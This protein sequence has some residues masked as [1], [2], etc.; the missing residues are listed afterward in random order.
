MEATQ[1]F[2]KQKQQREEKI[3]TARR[4][5]QELERRLLVSPENRTSNAVLRR[6]C[7]LLHALAQKYISDSPT[8]FD[9]YTCLMH[10]TKL[11]QSI[12]LKP[13]SNPFLNTAVTTLGPEIIRNS[14]EYRHLRNKILASLSTIADLTG[15]AVSS[16]NP[17][18]QRGMR[19]GYRRASEVAIMFLDDIADGD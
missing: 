3:F 2:S 18:F 13:E 7:Y 14:F 4:E 15:R 9:D 19:E 10:C 11:L 16:G 8:T 1:N 12:G 5:A 17:D 6:T